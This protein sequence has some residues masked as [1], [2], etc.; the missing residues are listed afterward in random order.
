VFLPEDLD[1]LERHSRDH[2]LDLMASGIDVKTACRTA[3]ESP[4]RIVVR[5]GQTPYY[6]E[7]FLLSE[8][9]FFDLFDFT[10]QPG[11]S[12]SALSRPGTI[13]ITTDLAQ[14]YFGDSDP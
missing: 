14:K 10:L 13:L 8:P 7:N 6:E 4:G 2:T 3:L 12:V 11:S 5:I 9:S 1:E